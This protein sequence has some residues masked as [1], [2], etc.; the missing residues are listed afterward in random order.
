MSDLALRPASPV[1]DLLVM[2]RRSTRLTMRNGDALLTSLALPIMLMLLFVYLFGGAIDTGTEY[3]T[4][5]VPGVIMLCASF[6]ASLTAV[7]VTNDMTGGIIDRFR[8]LDVR[9]A[10]VLGGHVAASTAR[11]LVSTAIV[12]G[13]AFLIGFR[14]SASFVDWLAAVGLLVV[15]IVALSWAAAAVGLLARTPEAA[16]GFTFF[17]MFLPYPSSAFVPVETMPSWIHGFADNQPFTPLI[18][19]LRGFLLGTPVGDSPWIALAWCVGIL[20][21]AVAATG[22]LFRRRTR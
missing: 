21:V 3:V 18:E 19:S 8:S 2:V 9:G 1:G 5:V 11:N 22:R 7:A 14:P 20:G 16:G 10:A 13:V 6:G 4:Y 17:V 15:A 12:L